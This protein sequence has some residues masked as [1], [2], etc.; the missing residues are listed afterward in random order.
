MGFFGSK[1]KP[2]NNTDA[3]DG[4]GFLHPESSLSSS[5]DLDTSSW[6]KER[7]S[8]QLELEDV[9]NKT[10]TSCCRKV[11]EF[12]VKSLFIIDISFGITMIVYGSL[13]STQFD[14]PAMATVLF[15]LILGSIHLSTSVLGSIS[16][17]FR[18]CQR[19][20]LI[21]TAYVG[22]Y[23]ALVYFTIVIALLADS[24]GLLQ[25]LDD[26]HE[27]SC[28]RNTI[29]IINTKHQTSRYA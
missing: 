24:N 1:S 29:R 27:V 2:A 17:F 10:K 3:A 23:V 22:P 9:H 4:S 7:T 18:G 13:I 25:Y 16:L 6:T 14:N 8:Q 15:N 5:R 28:N 11:I 21:I 12:L 26:N 19:F 20:G